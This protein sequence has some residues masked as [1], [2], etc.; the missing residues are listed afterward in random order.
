M[1]SF[2]L[3]SRR[4]AFSFVTSFE[5][6]SGKV[7]KYHQVSASL[8]NFRMISFIVLSVF[9]LNYLF[10]LFVGEESK[11]KVK[12]RTQWCAKRFSF[13]KFLKA[14]KLSYLTITVFLLLHLET[15]QA[16]KHFMINSTSA[17]KATS[18]SAIKTC[19][20]ELFLCSHFSVSF[21]RMQKRAEKLSPLTMKWLIRTREKQQKKFLEYK[22]INLWANILLRRPKTCW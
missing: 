5:S 20:F 17:I 15:I 16:L 10:F 19:S 9:V 4:R 14:T 7:S 8:I 21:V 22:A 3:L 12:Q 18:T 11:W 1:N 6:S 2:S 13:G